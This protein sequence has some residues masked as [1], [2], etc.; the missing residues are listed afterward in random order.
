M[1]E[2]NFHDVL[3]L[4]SAA[5]VHHRRDAGVQVQRVVHDVACEMRAIDS[6]KAQHVILQFINPEF[7]IGVAVVVWLAAQAESKLLPS[8]P[9][10]SRSSGLEK[11]GMWPTQLVPVQSMQD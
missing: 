3:P 2:V 5:Q 4:V 8:A 7:G 10:T 1:Q 11:P 9:P 6:Q